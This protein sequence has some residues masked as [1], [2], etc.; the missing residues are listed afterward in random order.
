MIEDA[1]R[2]DHRMCI[3]MNSPTD[4]LLECIAMG[5]TDADDLKRVSVLKPGTDRAKF[6]E[7]I[8]V[9]VFDKV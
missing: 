5:K 4:Q 3:N 8:Y 1:E 7:R 9:D 2:R 6:A